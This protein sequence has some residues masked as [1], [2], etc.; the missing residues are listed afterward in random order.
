V[1]EWVLNSATELG[2]TLSCR[3]LAQTSVPEF[4]NH[5]TPRA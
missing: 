1:L 2:K 3:Q 5:V 4:S